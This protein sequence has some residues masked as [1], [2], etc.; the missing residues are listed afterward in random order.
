MPIGS[1]MEPSGKHVLNGVE[2]MLRDQ[3]L[4]VALEDLTVPFDRDDAH[5]ERVVE[6]LRETAQG[7]LTALFVAETQ[8]AQFIPERVEREVARDVELECF[9]HERSRRGVDRLGLARAVVLI[10]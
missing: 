3:R 1:R 8:A 10:T 9:P 6:N 2:C 5:V 7:N 4:M